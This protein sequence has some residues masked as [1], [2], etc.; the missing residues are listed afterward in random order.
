MTSAIWFRVSLLTDDLKVLFPQFRVV[1]D[2]LAAHTKS[3][4]LLQLKPITFR[5]RME[6]W[7]VSFHPKKKIGLLCPIFRKQILHEADNFRISHF[8]LY[9]KYDII[10]Y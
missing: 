2:S 7:Q 5:I 3:S 10:V 4:S 9:V 8:H 1:R 6:V